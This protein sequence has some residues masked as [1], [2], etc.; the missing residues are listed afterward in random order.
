MKSREE[1]K[2]LHNTVQRLLWSWWT[3]ECAENVLEVLRRQGLCM[4]LPRTGHWNMS[5]S[6]AAQAAEPPIKHSFA[7]AVDIFYYLMSPT[8]FWPFCPIPDLSWLSLD[9][10]APT[11][12]M[13]FSSYLAYSLSSFL[14]KESSRSLPSLSFF[15]ISAWSL[16]S[17]FVSHKK[18][19]LTKSTKYYRHQVM[20]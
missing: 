7:I 14:L 3:P 19:M 11:C 5:G 13:S 9:V 6:R 20:S 17:I 18:K 4:R 10:F 8:K 15:W 2:L 1:P 12:F 16:F